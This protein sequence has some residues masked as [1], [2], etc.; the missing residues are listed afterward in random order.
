MKSAHSKLSDDN[1]VDETDLDSY[2]EHLQ[3][4]YLSEKTS[5]KLLVNAETND[6]SPS[7][8]VT[9]SPSSSLT[10]SEKQHYKRAMNE[11]KHLLKIG[12]SKLEKS[13]SEYEAALQKKQRSPRVPPLPLD[14]STSIEWHDSETT[15]TNSMTLPT[16]ASEL[17][18]SNSDKPRKSVRISLEPTT[19]LESEFS[20]GIDGPRQGPGILRFPSCS[21]ANESTD[22]KIIYAEL[23]NI[24]VKLN[25]KSQALAML[26]MELEEREELLE[27]REKDVAER[28]QHLELNEANMQR[29]KQVMTRLQGVEMEVE[30]KFQ[31][32]KECHASEI[33]RLSSSLLEK[34][35][36]FKR[37]KNSF[38]VLKTQN[39]E[40]KTQETSLNSMNEKLRAQNQKLKKRLENLQRKQEFDAFRQITPNQVL[41]DRTNK[42]SSA[43][44]Q[45]SLITDKTID[46]SSKV[47]INAIDALS[48]SL[49]WIGDVHLK[50]VLGKI[51]AYHIGR[52][53]TIDKCL[54]ILPLLVDV[55]RYLPQCSTLSKHHLPFIRFIHWSLYH[56]EDA[57]HALLSST[58]RRLGEEL[59][60]PTTV[61]VVSENE[62]LSSTLNAQ[63]LS[64]S[65]VMEMRVKSQVYFNS[66][67][68]EVRML[69]SLII[70]K[71]LH[72]V[73]LLAQ[74]FQ[75]MKKDLKQESNRQYFLEYHAIQSLL[76]YLTYKTN[77][78]LLSNAVDLMLQM[79]AE[80]SLLPT[81]LEQC[82]T[83][84]WFRAV[85]SAVRTVGQ[86][87]DTA[88]LEK[89][90][91]IL[92][93]LSKIKSNKRFFESFSLGRSLQ[94]L[95]RG[96]DSTSTFLSLNLRSILFNLN[97]IKTS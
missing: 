23:M 11:L 97:L 18:S 83:E 7:E 80:S 58:G 70:I 44:K 76:P 77:K 49:G 86:A 32:L 71:T 72:Q 5:E 93:K 40:L 38:D 90:S 8:I 55:V 91:V 59:I 87:N 52:E 54:K 84:S 42:N 37:I 96:C 43:A 62:T 48:V 20:T 92:Q 10:A 21:K 65:N 3:M 53:M 61:R 78:T 47:W 17:T 79:S 12:E 9:C 26:Q 81:F 24:H 14:P 29:T 33:E 50:P 28:E 34:T 95:Y 6:F 60:K 85:S 74:V 46:K 19:L 51:E 57:H 45:T 30:E 64:L 31:L 36:E 56:L 22:I 69:C 41:C 25:Q 82:S 66:S 94:E 15:L 73:D 35:K 89:L 68:P 88:A 4:K 75:Q 67:N 27:E 39:N 2:I 13:V 1:S 63:S 16:L